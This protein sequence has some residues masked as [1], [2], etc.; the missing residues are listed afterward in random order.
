M[1]CNF[2]PPA[3]FVPLIA[4]FAISRYGVQTRDL[5]TNCGRVLTRPHHRSPPSRVATAL[6]EPPPWTCPLLIGTAVSG[7]WIMCY[8]ANILT[9]KMQNV[10]L[11]LEVGD[12]IS[13]G[14][15]VEKKSL[16]CLLFK[17]AHA[18]HYPRVRRMSFLFRLSRWLFFVTLW[19]PL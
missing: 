17:Y 9:F 19:R 15:K 14:L 13:W 16:I 4:F 18:K 2:S 12:L 5:Q 8:A 6:A 11:I 3:Y 10:W 7:S 1:G